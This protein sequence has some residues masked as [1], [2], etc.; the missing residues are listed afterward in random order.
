MERCAVTTDKQSGIV[1][2]PN[3]WDEKNPG[4]IVDLLRS[5]IT[6]SA[7]TMDLVGELPALVF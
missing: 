4:Y 7:L 5:V 2:D 1:N 3:L 6:V